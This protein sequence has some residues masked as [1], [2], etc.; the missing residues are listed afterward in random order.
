MTRKVK[1]TFSAKQKREYGKLM[2][3]GGYSNIQVEK[4]SGAVNLLYRDGS[5]NIWLS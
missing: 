4:T 3:E 2:V 5:N 1:V